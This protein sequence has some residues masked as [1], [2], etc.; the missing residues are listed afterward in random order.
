MKFK[1]TNKLRYKGGPQTASDHE[2]V[3]N[4]IVP[5]FQLYIIIYDMETGNEDNSIIHNALRTNN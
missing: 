3:S 5:L 2:F 1:I 4:I